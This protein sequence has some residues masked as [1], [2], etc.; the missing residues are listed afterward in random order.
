[1]ADGWRDHRRDGG[2]VIDVATGDVVLD[3]MSMPHSSRI[4]RDKVWL[5]Y[6]SN[7]NFGFAELKTGKF[8]P[9]ALCRGYLRGLAF[10]GDFALVGLSLPR[11]SKDFE[12]LA[13]ED[14]H[15]EKGAEPICAIQVINL[16][17][18]DVVHTLQYPGL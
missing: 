9:V 2:L 18:G 16:R 3:G 1:M 7:G 11:G 4:Y 13:L 6:S 10:V 8:E 15:A 12:G 17:S 14:T 5:H